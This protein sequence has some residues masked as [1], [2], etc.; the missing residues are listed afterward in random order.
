MRIYNPTIRDISA[1]NRA[2]CDRWHQDVEPW[3]GADWS[4][5]MQGEAGEAGNVVKKLR[6]LETSAAARADEFSQQPL[7]DK[8]ALEMADTYLYWDL[9][10]YHYGIDLPDAIRLK[11]NATSREFGFPERLT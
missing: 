6:R 7:I 2:R 5:A 3:T 4:N 9:L 8:L 10:G 11:F 1:V